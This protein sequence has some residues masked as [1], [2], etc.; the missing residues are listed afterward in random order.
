MQFMPLTPS[1][2]PSEE[3]PRDFS[4]VLGGPLFQLYRRLHLSGASLE[5]PFRRTVAVTLI[6][7]APLLL[8]SIIG[9]VAWGG[10]KE[11]FLL[12]PDAHARL[13]IALPLLVGSELFVHAR[14]AT[15]ARQFVARGIVAGDALAKFQIAWSRAVRMRES[16]LAELALIVFVYAVGFSGLRN[17]IAPL[18]LDAWYRRSAAG[19]NHITAAGWWYTLVSLP[20]F[21]FIL[22]RWYF[23]L[24]IW[25][26]FLW[27]VAG[28][29]LKLVPTHPDRAA[30]LGFLADATIALAPFLFAHGTLF[31]GVMAMGI[32]F[33]GRTL[34]S[35]WPALAAFSALA[36]VVAFAPLLAFS[37]PLARARRA[38]LREYGALAQSYVMSFDSKWLRTAS[39]D[40][41]ELLGSAD[42]QSLSDMINSFQAAVASMRLIPISPQYAVRLAIVTLLPVA[43]LLLTVLPATELLKAILKGLF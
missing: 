40:T 7:W 5:L 29:G 12:D 21:Q 25:A 43:P 4:V 28:C 35:Y 42:I 24:A 13:L 19:M 10:V 30:G 23:R 1:M 31:A 6:A 3:L 15:T 38:G 34:I 32:Y 22:L 41:S 8:L 2:N 16:T 18:T 26:T 33:D 9:G 27:R 37:L 20:L 17:H 36:I 11:P 14:I 39:P